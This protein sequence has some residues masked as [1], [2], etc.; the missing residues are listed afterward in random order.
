MTNKQK[1]ARAAA[2][3]RRQR[4]Q[5]AILIAS[6]T[7][8]VVVALLAA[9]VVLRQMQKQNQRQAMAYQDTAI[10]ADAT[11]IPTPEVQVTAEPTAAPTQA[12]TAEPT[13]VPT[14]EPTATPKPFVYLPVIHKAEITEKRIA[15]TVD[16]LY[17]TD[18]LRTIVKLALEQKGKLTLFPVGEN[19]ERSGLAELVKSCVFDHGFEIENHTYTHAR[20]FRLSEQEMADEIWKQS[21]AVNKALGVDYKQHFFRLM[22]GDGS[23]DQRTHNYLTQLGYLGIAYWT[24]S[25]SDADMDQIKD[26]LSPGTIYLFHSTDADTEKLK[27][28]IPWAAKQ[29]YKLVTMNELLGLPANDQAPYSGVQPA[30]QPQSYIPDYRT[31]K[32]GDYA[33]IIIQ[34]QDR[35][36]ELGYLDMNGESTGYYGDKTVDAISEFQRANGLEVTGQADEATQKK[37]LLG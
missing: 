34:M 10:H 25:G 15:I 32:H 22:G 18:N 19:L 1:K 27:E 7:L 13:A 17:Q 24:I 14:P 28:F 4:R 3:R 2:R 30:P 21:Q 12:P 16:D 11:R 31:H 8:L 36:R 29:G 20:V 6:L 37:L 9:T 26:A 23:S 35:L 33:Y 5:R